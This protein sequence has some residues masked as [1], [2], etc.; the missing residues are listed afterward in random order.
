MIRRLILAPFRPSSHF[1][2]LA[3]FARSP[4]SA[5]QQADSQPEFDNASD[6]AAIFYRNAVRRINIDSKG[7]GKFTESHLL[8]MIKLTQNVKQTPMLFEAYYNLLGHFT[9]MSN[10]TVDKLMLK[11]LSFEQ[12]PLDAVLETFQNHNYLAYYPGYAVT[13]RLL[14]LN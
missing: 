9:V 2:T 6:R 7:R 4:F 11:V 10:S 3:Y 5:E 14:V 12:F 13:K 1:S 8:R